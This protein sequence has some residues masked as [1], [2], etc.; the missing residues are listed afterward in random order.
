M[1]KQMTINDEML[2]FSVSFYDT[3]SVIFETLTRCRCRI[4]YKGMNRNRCFISDEFAQQ[5][6]DSLPYTPV[7]GIFNKD[8]VDYE[9]HGE[10][11]SDGKIY[12][13]V[14]ENPNFAWEDHV[15]EDGIT[16]TYA[17]CDVYLFTGL[18]NEANLIP[19]KS[20]SMEI[21]RKTL[22]G[23]WR[24]C[25]E[26][27]MPFYFFISGSL[28]GLQALGDDVEPC[29]EGAAF[30]NKL[31]S[32]NENLKSIQGI[33]E[34]LKYIDAFNDKINRVF[35]AAKKRGDEKMGKELFRLSDNDKARK[36]EILS[37]PNFT[38][39][40]DW[41]QDRVV[42][43]VYEDYFLVYNLNS[44]GYERCSYKVN[45][46]S[47][48]IGEFQPVRIVDVTESEYDALLAIQ[49]LKGDFTS[50]YTMYQEYDRAVQSNEVKIAEFEQK[51]SEKDNEIAEKVS[52][53]EQLGQK[54]DLLT[55]KIEEFSQKIQQY[56]QEKVER[57]NLI[58]DL[59]NE[60]ESLTQFKLDSENQQKT[61]ILT[62][63]SEYLADNIIEEL[64]SKINDFSVADFK[65]EVCVQAVDAGMLN[66]KEN[67]LFFKSSS[68][69]KINSNGA[70][71]L[72]MKYT[73]GGNK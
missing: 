6:I 37:N 67:S 8:N 38:E 69:E 11:N 68:I 29:F 71:G 21:F 72:L 73:N 36:L 33:Q 64:K 56:E 2:K 4:F 31:K 17:C 26:D 54:F 7:K 18:Y 45:G 55:Q 40:Q 66:T 10:D 15:D 25:E 28:V 32:L 23:E 12:G 44:H 50:A 35:E 52:N 47:V 3:P 42:T 58:N 27:G 65:R 39:E 49:S 34:S 63:Y 14:P 59:K 13:I 43:D 16:R 60:N 41:I 61:E 46:D 22:V 62:K 5:L 48:E 70:L 20:Q 24:I 51:I 1:T 9:D 53:Y 19:T 30:F 57:E